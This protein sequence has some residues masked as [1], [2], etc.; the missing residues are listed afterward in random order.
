[1]LRWSLALCSLLVRQF[2]TEQISNTDFLATVVVKRASLWHECGLNVACAKRV[3]Q[4]RSCAS[5]PRCEGMKDKRMS[6]G[7]AYLVSCS[8]C[9]FLAASSAALRPVASASVLAAAL[10]ASSTS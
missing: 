3:C 10:R 9:R 4:A 2:W 8:K 7:L 1:M 6:A 5:D